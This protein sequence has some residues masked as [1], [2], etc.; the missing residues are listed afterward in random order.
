MTRGELCG[1]VFILLVVCIPAMGQTTTVSGVVTNAGPASARKSDLRDVVLWLVPVSDDAKNKTRQPAPLKSRLI[2]KNKTFEP[3]LL[4]LPAGSTVQ[5]PNR[6]PFFHNVFSLFNG[7]RFDL[8]L[9]EAGESRE[10]HFDRIG[11]S[12]IFCNIHPEMSAIV[13]TL[14]TPHYSLVKNDGKFAIPGVAAGVYDLHVF[15]EGLSTEQQRKL[16]RRVT[17]QDQ[18]QTLAAVELPPRNT[19]ERR[20]NLYGTEYDPAQ[21]HSYEH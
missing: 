19:A 18:P 7:K 4:V 9:Y 2:Q 5:F 16:I 6:D 10:V 21:P 12:Y 17:V 8:G 13:I 3:H 15:A 14:T 1:A 11:V 20:K